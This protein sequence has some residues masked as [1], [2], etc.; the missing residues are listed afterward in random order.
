ML[1]SRP[2]NVNGLMKVVTAVIGVDE[3]C[4]ANDRIWVAWAK[5]TKPNAHVEWTR[6]TGPSFDRPARVS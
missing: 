2:R 5:L 6:E 3:K 1:L 4:T